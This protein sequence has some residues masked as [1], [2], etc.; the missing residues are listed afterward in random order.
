MGRRGLGVEA[1][2]AR[3][4]VRPE[5]R[6][7]AVEAEDRAVHDGLLVKD[8]RVVDEIPRGEVV[9]AV[10]DD[11]VLREDP[12]DVRAG[13]ALLVLHHLHVGVQILD[14]DLGARHLLHADAARRV[15]DLPL[16]V[17][18]VDDVE[19]DEAERADA[20]R[21]EVQRRRR[22]R[23]RR[24]PGGGRARRGAWPG[25]PRRPLGG[26]GGA[27]SARAARR[28]GRAASPSGSPGPSSARTRGWPTPPLA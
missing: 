23:G 6:D 16:Q 28:S 27:S 5:R 3:P 20:R 13:E 10:D 7:L 22:C 12:I 18:H 17:R 26:A 25:R 8:A 4:L 24:R 2:V 21:R 14:R 15:E 11:V 9:A 19:V 1:A